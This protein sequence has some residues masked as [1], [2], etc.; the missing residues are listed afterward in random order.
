MQ[1]DLILRVLV[2]VFAVMVLGLFDAYTL[3]FD[4]ARVLR[5][6][7]LAEVGTLLALGV[8]IFAMRLVSEVAKLKKEDEA[9]STLEKTVNNYVNGDNKL[10]KIV[11][12][13]TQVVNPRRRRNA[14]L[15]KRRRQIGDL[16][17]KLNDKEARYYATGEGKRTR[18]VRKLIKFESHVA[19]GYLDKHRDVLPVQFVKLSPNF[20]TSGFNTNTKTGNEDPSRKFRVALKDNAANFIIPSLIVAF[21]VATFLIEN[22]FDF[23]AVALVVGIKVILL[24]FQDW[25]AKRYSPTYLGKTWIHDLHLRKRLWEEYFLWILKGGKPDAKQRVQHPERVRTSVGTT[26]VA[27]WGPSDSTTE[28][29]EPTDATDIGVGS[30][31]YNR[32]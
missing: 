15:T 31:R 2:W 29:S 23:W 27:V 16:L 13:L 14:F 9:N 26:S 18:R 22:E 19:S 4:L 21:I 11:E 17:E 24:L 10:R 30:L 12:F 6:D 28:P 8:L 5:A 7:Y 3:R 25:S 1:W 20:M 32:T